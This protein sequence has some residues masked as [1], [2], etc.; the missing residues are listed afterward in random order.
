MAAC[1]GK[2]SSREP[3]RAGVA[4]RAPRSAAHRRSVSSSMCSRAAMPVGGHR[5]RRRYPPAGGQP[6]DR[7][8]PLVVVPLPGGLGDAHREP[9]GAHLQHHALARPHGVGHQHCDVHVAAPLAHHGRAAATAP[10]ADRRAA[11]SP[12]SPRASGLPARS[13]PATTGS[14]I[15]RASAICSARQAHADPIER[16]PHGA[17]A[18]RLQCRRRGCSPHARHRRRARP[19]G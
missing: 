9:A 14:M 5:R 8:G 18:C 19:S 11:R 1:T 4:D 13:S 17:E 10:A 12:R 2:I 6:C 15:E 3:S 7:R 16:P